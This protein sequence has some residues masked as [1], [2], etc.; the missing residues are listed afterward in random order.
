[1]SVVDV[2]RDVYTNLS[3]RSTEP[4][5][6]TGDG[7]V[8]STPDDLRPR[9]P[10]PITPTSER[11]KSMTRGVGG[12]D[13]E[14]WGRRR[15]H[16]CVRDN[17]RNSVEG[18]TGSLGGMSRPKKRRRGGDQDDSY[19]EWTEELME[20]GLPPR[21]WGTFA[22]TIFELG[23]KHSSPKVLMKLMPTSEGLTTEHIKSHLQKHRLHSNRSKDEFLEF[24][25][26]SMKERYREF[27]TTKGWRNLP[28]HSPEGEPDE[29]DRTDSSE[30]EKVLQSLLDSDKM[31]DF[32]EISSRI[33]QDQIDLQQLLQRHVMAQVKLQGDF[34]T[35]VSSMQPTVKSSQSVGGDARQLLTLGEMPSDGRGGLDG[36]V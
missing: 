16:R 2:L 17:P 24:F 13:E 10:A 1:M 22:K 33:L 36:S 29:D 5:D 25:D 31:V 28:P 9:L 21:S 11:G 12:D 14:V 26:L 6:G 23:L 7:V 15:T 8:R 32:Q 30:T 27:C 4:Q 3:Q 20:S 35:Q 19:F 34:H 18:K